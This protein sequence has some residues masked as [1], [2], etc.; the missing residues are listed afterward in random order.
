MNTEDQQRFRSLGIEQAEHGGWVAAGERCIWEGHPRDR[1]LLVYHDPYLLAEIVENDVDENSLPE[2]FPKGWTVTYPRADGKLGIS[3]R[4]SCADDLA[5]QVAAGGDIRQFVGL[6]AASGNSGPNS[7]CSC[8][9]GKKF[10]KCC[11]FN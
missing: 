10:K 11:M 1:R 6:S 7:P 8:G 5:R 4:G 2:D 3:A 9:S